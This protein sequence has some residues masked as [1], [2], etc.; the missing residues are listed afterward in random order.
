MRRFMTSVS[1]SLVI[2]QMRCSG[3]AWKRDHQPLY[4]VIYSNKQYFFVLRLDR[5][6]SDAG[7][8]RMVSCPLHY[9]SLLIIFTTRLQESCNLSRDRRC[10][11]MTEQHFATVANICA[12]DHTNIAWRLLFWGLRNVFMTI[13]K[14]IYQ[15]RIKY[16][17][18][19]FICWWTQW[20]FLWKWLLLFFFF[21]NTISK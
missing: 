18:L 13:I 5:R 10:V 8:R 14:I 2:P 6:M 1:K 15:L 19:K 17:R 16:C 11:T 9:S 4:R 12:Q 21:K 20:L 3:A 7:R